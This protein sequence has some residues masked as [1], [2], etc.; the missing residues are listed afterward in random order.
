MTGI[1]IYELVEC[2]KC[3]QKYSV[4]YLPIHMSKKHKRTVHVSFEE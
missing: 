3:G 2:P 1:R 4:T